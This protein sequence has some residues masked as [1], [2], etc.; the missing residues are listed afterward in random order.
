MAAT[1]YKLSIAFEDG[2][3][4]IAETINITNPAVPVDSDTVVAFGDSYLAV[5]GLGIS[6]ATLYTTTGQDI[7]LGD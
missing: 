3:G 2:A 5:T 1:T 6:S 7:D 4:D